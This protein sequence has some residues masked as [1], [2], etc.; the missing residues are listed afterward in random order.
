MAKAIFSPRAEEDLRDIW[1]AIAPEN[2]PAA[3]ALLM[4]LLEKADLAATQPLMGSPRPELSPTARLLVE[5]RYVIIYEPMPHGIFVAAIV[6]GAR[7]VE[8]WLG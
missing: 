6:H 1:R 2:P 8:T 4:R 3:D 5:G 7:D